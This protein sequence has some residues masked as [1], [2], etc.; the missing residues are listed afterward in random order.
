VDKIMEN[1]ENLRFELAKEITDLWYECKI[2]CDK[3]E[4]IAKKIN[5]NKENDEFLLP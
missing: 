2:R 3:I 4:K 5:K 1:E